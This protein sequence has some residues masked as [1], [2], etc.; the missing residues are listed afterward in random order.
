M[1][2]AT[3][4]ALRTSPDMRQ[5]AESLLNTGETLSTFIEDSLKRNIERRQSNRDFIARG[6]KAGADARETGR[7]V[8]VEQTMT[9]L[10]AIRDAKRDI[11]NTQ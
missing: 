5:M 9:R 2:T 11:Q 6:L 3:F 8:S 7:Y 10:R 1:R 4:P